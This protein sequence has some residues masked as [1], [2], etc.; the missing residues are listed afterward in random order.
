MIES[1]IQIENGAIE[2]FRTKWGFIY[3]NADER[4]AADEKACEASSYSE[5]AGEHI[6]VRTVDAPFDYTA[7]FIIEAPNKDLANVNAKIAAFN[8]AIR[9]TTKDSDIKRKRKITFYNLLNRVKIV[10]YPDVIAE[11][12]DVYHS[13]RYGELDFAVVK[14]KIRVNDPKKCDFNL[15]TDNL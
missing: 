9:E 3:I 10:G 7:E 14:L 6:D 2:N 5:E 13:N 8:A 11:P 15:N 4:T 12:T 1:R